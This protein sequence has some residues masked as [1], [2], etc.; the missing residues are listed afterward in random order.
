[1]EEA[2]DTMLDSKH[3]NLLSNRFAMLAYQMRGAELLV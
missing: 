2:N 1:M 3:I